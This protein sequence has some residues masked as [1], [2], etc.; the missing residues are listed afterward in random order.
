[1]L[2]LFLFA[3]LS[4]LI[5]SIFM[6]IIENYMA[7]RGISSAVSLEDIGRWFLFMLKGKFM[8]KEIK[9]LAQMP[10][11]IV[12]GKI[13]HYI[14][15]GGGIALLYPLFLIFFDI[16]MDSNHLFYGMIFGFL[17]NIFPWFWMMPSFGWG[18]AGVKRSPKANTILAPTVSHIVYGLGLGLS[19]DFFCKIL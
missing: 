15:A 12:A 11:E 2:E 1:M 19:F 10:N 17:T 4:G 6:D 13:F 14:F 16:K 8:H 18:I 9:S 3:Y 7:K 5:G